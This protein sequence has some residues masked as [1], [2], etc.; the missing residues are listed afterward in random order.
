MKNKKSI[1]IFLILFMLFILISNCSYAYDI[2]QLNGGKIA[3]DLAENAAL[4]E[5]GNLVIKV[6][7][8]TG[9]AVSIIV[10]IILGI[11]YMTG[12]V[13]EKAEYKKTLLPYI[14][15]AV[16]VFGA[17]SIVSIFYNL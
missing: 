8:M 2:S 14:I 3:N 13:E 17:S 15:G 6:V 16:C 10:I 5:T 1:F 4:K 7:A 11:K 9:S 12:S